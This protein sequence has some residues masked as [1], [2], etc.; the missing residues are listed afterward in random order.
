MTRR[1]KPVQLQIFTY[2]T[3]AKHILLK[4]RFASRPPSH[5]RQQDETRQDSDKTTARQHKMIVMTG[6]RQDNNKT[7]QQQNKTTQLQGQD[8]HKTKIGQS[9]DKTSTRLDRHIHK[10]R[11]EDNQKTRQPQDKTI[12]R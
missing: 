5:T 12:T 6:T 3:K 8:N 11:Q 10:R 9:Q 1:E 4:D 7:R 2:K